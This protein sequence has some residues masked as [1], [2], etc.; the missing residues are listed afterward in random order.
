MKSY[1]EF[2]RLEEEGVAAD[3]AAPVGTVPQK[4][5]P[6]DKKQVFVKQKLPESKSRVKLVV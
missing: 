5:L 6:L 1:K 4:Y 3:V 2:K